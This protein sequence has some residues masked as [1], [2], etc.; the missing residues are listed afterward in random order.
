MLA[1]RGG[2]AALRSLVWEDR[3][4]E[5][6][7]V[8]LPPEDAALSAVELAPDGRQAAVN[9]SVQGNFDI[10]LIDVARGLA[11]RFTFDPSTD[12]S[13]IWSPDG[14]RVVFRSLRNGP[15]DLYEKPANG[16]AYAVAPDGRFLMNVV[17]DDAAAVPIT[18]VL[19][20]TAGLGN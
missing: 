20:W 6:E 7:G 17:A 10:W 2:G 13:P 14:S 15:A 11:S 12:S 5:P 4:G 18:L 8:L 16:S 1:Y 9:R 3:A 19:N